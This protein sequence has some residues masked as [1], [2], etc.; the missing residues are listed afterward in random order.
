MTTIKFKTA[1]KTE[2][3]VVEKTA[4]DLRVEELV[5]NII[6]L[7]PEADQAKKVVTKYEAEYKKLR[8]YAEGDPSDEFT[9]ETDAGTVTYS[10][11]SNKTEITD[12]EAAFEILGKDVFLKLCTIPV[13]KLKDYMS[14]PELDKCTNTSRG[15]TRSIKAVLKR[16]D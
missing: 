4:E 3:K 8:D 12:M 15:G 16:Q 13:G 5:Q 14:K 1:T 2:T 10:A 6:Q 9:F 7:K 11:L